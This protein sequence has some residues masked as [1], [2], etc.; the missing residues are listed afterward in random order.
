MA[1]NPHLS[2]N[3]RLSL[4]K[5]LRKM[6]EPLLGKLKEAEVSA[7]L[8]G[9]CVRDLLLG[10]PSLDIDVVV[11][12]SASALAKTA[13]RLYKAKLVTHAQF[14]T[15]TLLF[16]D[17]RHLDIA[18]ARTET[19]SEPAVLPVVEPAS[20]QEDLYR[21]DFSINAIA[22][23]LNANDF[24]H[25]WD[26]F[27]GLD[28]L[29]AGKIRVLHSESFK[30]DPT[31]L[32]RAARFAGRFGYELEWKTR[33]WLLESIAQQ[34][35]SKLSGAR[36]REELIPLL[37]EKDPR[38][39]FQLLS[40][41]GALPSLISNLHWEKSHDVLFGH[42]IKPGLK[43]D[44]VLL[45]LLALLHA[46]PVPKAIGSL[47]HLMFPQATIAA[48]EQALTLLGQLR[49][50]S[51]DFSAL[52]TATRKPLAPEVKTFLEKAMKIRMLVPKKEPVEQWRRYQDS[53]PCLS[54]RDIR[55]LGYKPG[56]V[57]TKIFDALRQARWEGKLRTREEEIRFLTQSFPLHGR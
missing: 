45:R 32:F 30:D 57:F 20:L 10:Q 56:P 40:S 13:A 9:G 39:A 12:G 35:P 46:A 18:C 15:H 47:G 25:V 50:G 34:L 54:G 52:R 43:G 44:K 26:A 42:M 31:R 29:R 33:E 27:G 7:Y 28:D 17:G 22:L 23:S 38:P 53:A 2:S 14:L 16:P 4:P 36:I 48:V 21:R 1:L 8:V 3:T 24:G 41:W 55:D 6:L 19:Y 37:L 11:E 51:L 5:D 49:D